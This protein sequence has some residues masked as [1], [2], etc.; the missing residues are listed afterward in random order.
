ME[1]DG[2]GL[3]ESNSLTIGPEENN[4]GLFFGS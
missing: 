2:S 3:G 4:K 1:V